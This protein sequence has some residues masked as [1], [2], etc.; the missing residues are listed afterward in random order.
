MM[1][2]RFIINIPKVREML[3]L[4]Y[5]TPTWRLSV[6]KMSNRRATTL[7]FNACNQAKLRNKNGAATQTDALLILT[8]DEVVSSKNSEKRK[9]HK[10]DIAK[11]EQLSFLND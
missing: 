8:F 6:D 1:R 11:V 4:L 9:K 5:N 10:A 3:K 7:Y 2:R